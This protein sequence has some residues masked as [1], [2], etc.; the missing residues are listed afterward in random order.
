MEE[1]IFSWDERKDRE[2]RRKHGISFEE[3][4]TAFADENARLKYLTECA[5]S[6]KKLTLNW[7]S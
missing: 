1:I 7:A 4:A 6:G 5:H 2:N 3:A